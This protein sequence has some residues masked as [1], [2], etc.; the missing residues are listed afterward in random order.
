MPLVMPGWLRRLLPAPA[1]EAMRR[2]LWSLPDL[3]RTLHSGLQI[4]VASPSDWTIYNEVFAD[5]E[6]DA[7]L[8]RLLAG[9]RG[10][11]RLRILDLGANVGYFSLRAADRLLRSP[12][13][14]ADWDL[15]LV[16]ASRRLV[17]DIERRLL[18]QPLLAGRVR[19]VHGLAGRRSGTGVLQETGCHFSNTAAGGRGSGRAS[20]RGSPVPYVDL[21]AL[22]PEGASIDL[23]KC[24]IE[25]SELE[26][27]ESYGDLLRRAEVAVIELHHELCDTARC[28]EILRA[29]GFAGEER[30]RE[31]DRVS[32]ALFWR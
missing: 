32:V 11:D 31:D 28:Y 24:D 2:R 7:A 3:R 27:L 12:L 30:L 29:A 22:F 17:G 19:V 4:E 20:G 13:A 9:A 15:V 6:Y 1:A 10:K 16:E 5:G 8:E 25:G 14:E 26:L 23:L 18:S 21:E